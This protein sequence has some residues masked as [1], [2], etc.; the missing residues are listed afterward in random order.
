MIT[1]IKAFFRVVFRKLVRMDGSPHKIAGGLAL[2]VFLGILPGVGP[3]A[4][5]VLAA[6]LHL[7]KAAAFLGSILTNTWFSVVTFVAAVKL[8]S[9]ATGTDWHATYRQIKELMGHFHW[10]DLGDASVEEI[11][12]PVLVGYAMVGLASGVVVYV[13]ALIVVW[14]YRKRKRKTAGVL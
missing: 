5:L 1:K 14:G 2:G 4:S 11:L 6:L 8:G 9:W 12:K 7:N 3:V 10:R 13:V